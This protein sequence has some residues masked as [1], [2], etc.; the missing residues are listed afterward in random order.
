MRQRL[1]DQWEEADVNY[2]YSL[3]QILSG[4]ME[5]RQAEKKGGDA[6]WSM[7]HKTLAWV[8]IALIVLPIS[9]MPSITFAQ[10]GGNCG[11]FRSWIT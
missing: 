2:P 5:G 7:F 3:L 9:L 6:M 10:S 1:D 4:L 11:V 8:L